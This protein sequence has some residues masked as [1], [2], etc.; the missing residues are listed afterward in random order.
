MTLG[1]HHNLISKTFA[2]D[3][4]TC[5]SCNLNCILHKFSL[6]NHHS[7]YCCLSRTKTFEAHT[8]KFVDTDLI[9]LSMSLRSIYWRRPLVFILLNMLAL[10][11]YTLT[12]TQSTDNIEDTALS[13]NQTLPWANSWMNYW[14]RIM[15]V[16]VTPSYMYASICD[17]RSHNKL[18]KSFIK[19]K[20]GFRLRRCKM[21]F[22]ISSRI[23]WFKWMAN[24]ELKKKKK[25]VTV[26]IIIIKIGKNYEL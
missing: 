1:F 5:I 17:K 24:L 14:I 18:Y 10:Q 15:L 23:I 25:K 12:I 3:H 13:T 8:R 6:Y 22:F 20:L 21:V 26:S 7:F 2:V 19:D 11:T 9:E 4:K 16:Q